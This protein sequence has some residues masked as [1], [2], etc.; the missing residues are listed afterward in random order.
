MLSVCN[1]YGK[2]TSPPEK[3]KFYIIFF[4]NTIFYTSKGKKS[5]Y[6]FAS[7]FFIKLGLNNFKHSLSDNYKHFQALLVYF[8]HL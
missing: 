4:F 3:S 5:G 6:K 2:F 1:T 8:L 7:P